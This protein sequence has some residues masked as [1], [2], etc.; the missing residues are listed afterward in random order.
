M[1]L[2]RTAFGENNTKDLEA[3]IDEM[4]SQLPPLTNFILPVFGHSKS[5]A[6]AF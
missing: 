4:D 6:N 1:H 3:W 5:L 2:K